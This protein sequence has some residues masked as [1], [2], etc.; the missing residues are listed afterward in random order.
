MF[1]YI[2]NKDLDSG[3]KKKDADPDTYLYAAHS[4]RHGAQQKVLEFEVGDSLQLQPV[5]DLLQED[6][7]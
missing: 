4:S 2:I 6:V 5:Q 3:G 1:L 7:I